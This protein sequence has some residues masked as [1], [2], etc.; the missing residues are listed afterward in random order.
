MA[1]VTTFHDNM[2]TVKSDAREI[3]PYTEILP[4]LIDANEI[5]D[6]LARPYL[7]ADGSL[8][9]SDVIDGTL[10]SGY[11]E[12]Y[13]ESVQLWYR[14]LAG[15]RYI[16]ATAHLR[17]V[18]NA[19]PFQQGKLLLC[20]LPNNKK[21]VGRSNFE[22]THLCNLC[23]S[24]Q[25]PNV[26]LDLQEG[27][28]MLEIPYVAPTHFHDRLDTNPY[29]WGKWVLKVLSPFATGTGS[30]NAEWSLFLHFT[31]AELS[32]PIFGPEGGLDKKAHARVVKERKKQTKTGAV[33][34]F[35]DSVGTAAGYLDKI[36]V[37]G[38]VASMV[39]SAAGSFADA[40]AVFGWSKPIT[41]QLGMVVYA[42]NMHQFLNHDGETKAQAFA[43]GHNPQ[44][45]IVSNFAGTD[46][47]E[48]SFAYLKQVEAYVARFSWTLSNVTSDILYT[49]NVAPENFGV[50]TTTSTTYDLTYTS[51]PP[52]FWLADKF[53]YWRGGIK[54]KFKIVKTPYHSGRIVVSFAVQDASHTITQS[55]YV[56]REIIDIRATNEFVIIV[57]YIR[58]TNYLN[59]VSADTEDEK[60]LGRL[61]VRVLN[62]LKAPEAASSSIEMLVYASGADDFELAYPKSFRPSFCPEGGL[63]VKPLSDNVIG[64][65][66]DPSSKVTN[67]LMSIADVF[68]S[69]KQLITTY[70]QIYIPGFTSQ[71]NLD[72]WPFAQNVWRLADTTVLTTV[73]RALSG[74]FISELATGYVYSRGS[75]R[76]Y[77]TN[78][79]TATVVDARL[80]APPLDTNISRFYT[81]NLPNTVN[82]TYTD[83]YEGSLYGK[84]ITCKNQQWGTEVL[85]PHFGKTPS[86][87]N[88]VNASVI[89]QTPDSNYCS[90]TMNVQ[91]GTP[92]QV[93]TNIYRAGGDDYVFGYFVGFAPIA[94][95]VTTP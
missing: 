14:K 92:S 31:N 90:L 71:A 80:N 57:P 17:L 87:L 54:L 8:S 36:P 6:F 40:F 77:V 56:L 22:V 81:G 70:R 10:A 37:I 20:F 24:T 4:Q 15:Y 19:T 46:L 27:V 63:E 23:Q 69:V 55:A 73:P 78:G 53:T 75:V 16:R 88:Y 52:A 30:V 72:F 64:S 68:V 7:I 82:T 5:S 11:I 58:K 93:F 94:T 3:M 41:D 51:R 61:T 45:P 32:G 35:L 38:S 91:T 18:V 47:D 83:V 59:T 33:S 74:D 65:L 25:L 66:D 50:S 62:E 34:S 48:M 49:T 43:L 9:A 28:A 44:L 26:E 76:V 42:N 95:S 39:S 84:M 85:V 29:G 60:T 79:T 1:G 21:F 12:D 2:D 13:L 89:P 86:R 67:N